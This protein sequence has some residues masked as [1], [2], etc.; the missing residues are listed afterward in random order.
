MRLK[1]VISGVMAVAMAATFAA[2]AFAATAGEGTPGNPS[3]P[4]TGGSTGGSTGSIVL[5]EGTPGEPNKP[6]TGGSTGGNTSGIVLPEDATPGQI[7]GSL[8]DALKKDPTN[9]ENAKRLVNT[10]NEDKK[11]FVDANITEAMLLALR[12][13]GKAYNYTINN[14]GVSILSTKELAD[15][16][17]IK[18]VTYSADRA[19]F[20]ANYKGGVQSALGTYVTISIPYNLD[21]SWSWVSDNGQSGAVIVTNTGKTATLGFFAPHFTKYTLTKGTT[22]P[23]TSGS[24]SGSVI[25]AT[26]ADMN[27][28]MMGIVGTALVAGAGIA[29]VSVKKRALSK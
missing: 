5:P 14:V 26:G 8:A 18:P 10:L 3:K 28:I 11:I 2:S 17:E 12:A 23:P 7:A 1:K 4:G 16:L 21:G 19:V 20:E 29:F 9:Y 22:T 25:K 27:T 6:G 13:Q 24:G 15:K